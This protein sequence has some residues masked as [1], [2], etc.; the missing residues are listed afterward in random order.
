M[1]SNI[2]LNTQLGNQMMN[3]EGDALNWSEANTRL[4]NAVAEQIS[5]PDLDVNFTQLTDCVSLIRSS[6]GGQADY[7]LYEMLHDMYDQSP[8]PAVQGHII[9]N[10][11][12]P[13]YGTLVRDLMAS[14]SDLVHQQ[15]G[16]ESS[17]IIN[18][19][20]AETNPIKRCTLI[21]EWARLRMNG[22]SPSSGE[23]YTRVMLQ[24]DVPKRIEVVTEQSSEERE[25]GNNRSINDLHLAIVN[26]NL[27]AFNE[28]MLEAIS[29]GIDLGELGE[30]LALDGP[31][32]RRMLQAAMSN[33]Q[34]R[35]V[36][37]Q[38]LR[39]MPRMDTLQPDSQPARSGSFSVDTSDVEALENLLLSPE[40]TTAIAENYHSSAFQSHMIGFMLK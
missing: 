14:D 40:P 29:G 27:N 5:M 28:A 25:K 11:M 26:R 1:G 22:Q 12:M 18:S 39:D 36:A 17:D 38:I 15:L 19:I 24:M 10:F 13:E 3:L 35:V 6:L 33:P 21:V 23:L 8:N 31:P 20:L 7:L 37:S 4:V 34:L 2:T 32:A 30:L 9:G 16:K